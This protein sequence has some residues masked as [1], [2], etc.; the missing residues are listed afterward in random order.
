MRN[1]TLAAAGLALLLASPALAEAEEAVRFALEPRL[2]GRV[3]VDCGG[4]S[5]TLNHC[6]RGF[7]AD[8]CGEEGCVPQVGGTLGFTGSVTSAMH[9]TDLV[10]RR[11]ASVWKSCSFVGGSTATVFVVRLGDCSPQSYGSDATFVCLQRGCGY[12]LLPPFTLHGS[13]GPVAG[14]AGPTGPWRASVE[15]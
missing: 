5:P 12:Y 14:L 9:G 15:S 10:T 3:V 11:P 2:L 6:E 13:T 8:A 7:D 1:A 4:T